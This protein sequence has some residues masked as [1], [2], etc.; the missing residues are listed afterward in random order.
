MNGRTMR[1]ALKPF[2]VELSPADQARY[3]D[4]AASD[5]RAILRHWTIVAVVAVLTLAA[6]IIGAIDSHLSTFLK[7]VLAAAGAGVGTFIILGPL[8]YLASLAVAPHRQRKHLRAEGERLIAKAVTGADHEKTKEQFASAIRAGQALGGLPIEGAPLVADWMARTEVLVKETLGELEAALVAS[9]TGLDHRREQIR[10]L[11]AQVGAG[12]LL[13]P[14]DSWDRYVFVMGVAR[15]SVVHYARE[16]QNIRA[17]FF[18]G[19]DL[20]QQEARQWV[21]AWLREVRKTL[22][23]APPLRTMATS[24]WQGGLEFGYEKG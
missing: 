13:R 18:E 19:E 17:M 15:D 14:S 4:T 9:K 23:L 10:E 11:G 7:V 21:D 1:K 24:P 8:V 5:T 20:T 6:S 2:A 3:R 22:D 12:P 16:G